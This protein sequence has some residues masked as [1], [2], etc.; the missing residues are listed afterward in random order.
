MKK[1]YVMCIGV[2]LASTSLTANAQA[3][4]QGS[5]VIDGY[6]GWGSLSKA[7]LKSITDNSAAK[8][9]SLGPIG[10]RLEYMA[11][12]KIGVGFDFN[13]TDNKVTWNDKPTDSSATYSYE[14]NV[15]RVRF[16]PRM[17]IHFGGN[18]NFDSYFGVAAGYRSITRSFSS[19]DPDYTGGTTEGV[20]PLAMRLALGARYFFTDNFG[21]NMEF[22]LGGG[23]MIH[24]GVSAKF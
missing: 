3:V 20:N 7:F 1:I 24:A 10:A 2:I 14:Y 6:Y 5:V 9:S 18:E 16:M 17:N 12:D 11:S 8:I 21:L 4:Q 15:T 13:Y 23:Y 22:G 19:N